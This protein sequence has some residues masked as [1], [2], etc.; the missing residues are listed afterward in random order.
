[1]WKRSGP[2]LV[3]L[4][5]LLFIPAVQLKSWQLPRWFSIDLRHSYKCLRLR[6]CKTPSPNKLKRLN[7]EEEH[8]QVAPLTV[9]HTTSVTWSQISLQ[10]G[11]QTSIASWATLGKAIPFQAFDSIPT[12]KWSP[13]LLLLMKIDR[14]YVFNGYILSLC[15]HSNLM[16]VLPSSMD[17]PEGAAVYV[18]IHEISWV[19]CLCSSNL[20]WSLEAYVS[21]W[22]WPKGP[23][24]SHVP[25]N[26]VIHCDIFSS[27]LATHSTPRPCRMAS[28]WHYSSPQV[29]WP[30]CVRNKLQ[31]E[32]SPELHI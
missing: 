13:L 31:A 7:I 10:K 4:G 8:F 25:W 1:M 18:S 22:H 5:M 23:S 15:V 16:Y 27:C 24:W 12:M 6:C 17:Q 20:T 29:R 28:P 3:R 30:P 26:S 14:T 2:S 19:G 21:E 9:G 32:L 11:A